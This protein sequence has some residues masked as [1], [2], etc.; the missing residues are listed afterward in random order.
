MKRWIKCIFHGI[1]Q[2]LYELYLKKNNVSYGK[3][4]FFQ[5][6]AHIYNIGKISLGDKVCI[7]SGWKYNPI[8][9]DMKTLLRVYKDAELCIGNN[10]GMSNVSMV[11]CEKITIGNGVQIGGGCKLYDTDFHPINADARLQKKNELTVNR[12]IV[13]EE[14]VFLGAH[15]IILKGSHIGKGSVVGAGSVVAG[16]IPAGEI[17]AGNPAR[18]LKKIYSC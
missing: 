15:C 16:T 11:V 14:N 17:W 9:G 6:W 10:V 18:F 2:G 3:K 13:I 12:P 4:C 5:G 7:N 1:S 8:G